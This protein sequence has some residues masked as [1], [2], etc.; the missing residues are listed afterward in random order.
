MPS[1]PHPNGR[2]VAPV[3]PNSPLNLKL[4][5]LIPQRADKTICATDMSCGGI[6]PVM[7]R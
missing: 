4:E 3:C 5:S 6:S 7:L 1:E 2:S